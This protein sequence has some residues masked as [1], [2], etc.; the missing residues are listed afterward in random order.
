MRMDADLRGWDLMIQPAGEAFVAAERYE[1]HP[2]NSSGR[3][4]DFDC[5]RTTE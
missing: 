3:S 4:A 2:K 1:R 5:M